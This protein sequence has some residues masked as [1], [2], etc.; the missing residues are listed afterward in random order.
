MAPVRQ[1]EAAEDQAF[2]LGVQGVPAPGRVE[3]HR[4]PLDQR[5]EG[6]DS[7]ELIALLLGAGRVPAQFGQPGV[8]PV[9]VLLLD[10]DLLL[11]DG[12]VAQVG[13]AP[14]HACHRAL[15]RRGQSNLLL[16]TR[17]RRSAAR[18]VLGDLQ[19]TDAVRPLRSSTRGSVRRPG[20]SRRGSGPGSCAATAPPTCSRPRG[21][22]PRSVRRTPRRDAPAS[23]CARRPGRRSARCRGSAS[24]IDSAHG[25]GVS[26]SR[27]PTSTAAGTSPSAAR[28]SSRCW[29]PIDGRKPPIERSDA[30]PTARMVTARAAA[31]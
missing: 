11:Q 1:V 30:R 18:S 16:F 13:S 5:A 23:A 25:G 22:R 26:R 20:R 19:N 24:A 29:A 17:R 7:G 10:G 8:D 15:A 14:S 28:V 21:P 3:H 9:D 12:G 27:S 2:V 6:A 31:S 4:V